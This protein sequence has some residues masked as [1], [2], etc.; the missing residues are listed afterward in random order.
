MT[1]LLRIQAVYKSDPSQQ[2]MTL[3]VNLKESH[4]RIDS[5]LEIIIFIFWIDI[6]ILGYHI[7]LLA[8]ALLAALLTL[9]MYFPASVSWSFIST[10][11]I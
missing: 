1:S 7:N 2:Y 3:L 9:A 11:S 8:M 6:Y 10:L 5:I 4:I